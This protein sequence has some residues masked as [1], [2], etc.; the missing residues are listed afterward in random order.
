MAPVTA[1]PAP[2][3]GERLGELVI[4]RRF[5]GPETSANGGYACGALAR[6]VGEPAEITLRLPPPL[7]TPLAV[8][9][10]E[11]GD[12]ARLLDGDAVVAEGRPVGAV[13]AEP[14]VLPSFD[15]AVAAT[16]SHPWL[17][18]RH[19]LS[20]CFVCG[21]E[22][23]RHADG[24]GVTFG[25]LAGDEEIGAAPFVPDETVAVDGIVRPE[26]VWAA[27]DCP[28]YAP[29]IWRVSGLALLGRLTAQRE[30]DVRAG[31]R[32]AAVGWSLGAEGRKHETASA[33]VDV[34]GAVV[35]RARATWIELRG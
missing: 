5:N 34:D 19:M 15:E 6:F 16:A 26:V 14:P 9:A 30:R 32:L 24:L 17:G 4:G 33:L 12:G 23:G 11:D 25:A 35:A 2:A 20:D 18:T 22:R 7:E 27:L 10:A 13:D 3:A 1:P 31:E 29:S 21:P 28:S 8:H